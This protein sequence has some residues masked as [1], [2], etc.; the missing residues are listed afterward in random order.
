MRETV[1]ILL[2]TPLK[3]PEG[4]VSRIVLREPTFDE[5]LSIG[6]P[7]SIAYSDGGT[8]F[9]VENLENIQRYI[10]HCVVEPKDP[11]TLKQ[12]SAATARE[13]KKALLGFFQPDEESEVSATSPTT[14]PSAESEA[15][16]STRSDS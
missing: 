13:V 5:Y 16:A 2:K 7:Y 8:P 4:P 12:A 10:A 3:A 1:T 6:D 9:A 11:A 15:T 14:S